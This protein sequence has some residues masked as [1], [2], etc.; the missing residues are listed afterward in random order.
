MK[1]LIVSGFLGAGKTTFIKKMVTMTK[2][3]FVILENEYGELG[4]DGNI[5]QESK[6]DS[7]A[8]I[9]IWELTEGCICCS[10]KSDFASSIL[11][12]ANTLDPEYLIVEPTG[13]GM[14]SNIIQ[15]IGKIEYE[16]IQLLKPL[17][18]ID[19][20]CFDKDM[21]KYE[22]IYKD[23]ICNTDKVLFS[24]T[25]NIDDSEI[26]RISNTI[27]ELNP[28]VKLE[29]E[30]YSQKPAGWWNDLLI[31]SYKG[32][33]KEKTVETKAPDLEN[34]GF[35]DIT[36]NSVSDLVNLLESVIWGKM[37][38]I[39][40]AKG[41]LSINGYGFRFDVVDGVYS[42]VGME[43]SDNNNIIFIGRG[44]DKD[45]LSKAIYK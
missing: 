1:I 13:V 7:D 20:T 12:I 25:E 21:Q 3:H 6:R 22:E 27:H 35:S 17:T 40:R 23:Q 44:L 38:D 28:K 37:G 18:I 14:L 34:I 19:V 10:V 43:Q 31:D 30:H 45:C 9:N 15:N 32:H 33:T 2:K 39:R 4:V 24:K 29:C 11:T 5:L 26:A 42:I 36:M 16:R 41:S 8:E